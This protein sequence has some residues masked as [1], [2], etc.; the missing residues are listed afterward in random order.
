MDQL[1]IMR[2]FVGVTETLSFR[3]AGRK[4]GISGSLISRHVAELERTLGVRLV[5]RTTRTI[6]LTAAGVRYAEF[7]TRII[8]EID[9]E[10]AALGNMH[11]KLE[12]PLAI[13]GPK[14]MGNKDVV[15][16]IIEFSA[17][18]PDIHIRF[19]VNG[20][21][22]R[23][24]DFLE[25]GFDVAI[26]AGDATY[27]TRHVRNRNVMLRKI[28]DLDFVLCASPDYLRRAGQPT[29]ATKLTDHDCIVNTNY[30]IW[31]LRQGGHDVHL[32][33]SDPVYSANSYLSLRKAALA[34]RGI[35]L[36]PVGHIVNELA[37][38]SLVRV[39]PGTEVPDQLLYALHLPDDQSPARVRLF[40]DFL[41]D[42]FRQRQAAQVR[43]TAQNKK[44]MQDVS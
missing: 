35:A 3:Q 6:N 21:S 14:W 43:T 37:N 40:V 23:A 33:I 27:P 28:A 32:K 25:H 2:S 19:E 26:H 24:Y 15:D 30:H 34:G 1:T 4:L 18:Y 39:L 9:C 31:H 42:R 7:A 17:R 16:A 10:Q 22:E 5:N 41:S 13:I 44:V 12:G 36:L 29:E 8:N 20:T 38:G 11:D